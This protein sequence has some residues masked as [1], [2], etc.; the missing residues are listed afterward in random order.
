MES[1]RRNFFNG[2]ENAEQ[3]MLLIGWNKIL[4]SKKNGAIYGIRGALDNSSSYSRRCPW[5][6]IVNEV[7]KLAS[8]GIDLLSLV[9]KKV[10]NGEATSFWNDVWLGD[11]PLKQ[12]YSRLYFL[13]LDKHVSVVSKLRANSLISSFRRSPRSD[14]SGDFSVK[15][16]REFIDDSM[17]PKTDVP[18]RWIKSIPIKINI[19]SWRVS[20]NK[21]PTRLNLSLR[22]L[23]ISSIICP[24]YS[25]VVESTSHLLF[26]CQFAHQLMIKVVYWWDLEYQDFHSYENWILWFKNLRVSK[27]LKD[28]FEGVFDLSTFKARLVQLNIFVWNEVNGPVRIHGGDYLITIVIK[29]RE[30]RYVVQ[31]TKPI[32]YVRSM[33]ESDLRLSS[34]CYKLTYNLPPNRDVWVKTDHDWHF[35]VEFSEERG[36]LVY[37]DLEICPSVTIVIKERPKH[38]VVQATK[39]FETVKSM[40]EVDLSLSPRCYKL[41]YNLPPNGDVCVKTYHDWHFVVQFSKERGYFMYLDLEIC[42]SG[43]TTHLA[44]EDA[45]EEEMMLI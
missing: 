26:S 13:E 2:V 40:I 30:K 33:I 12:M 24:L 14:P 38:N 23:D 16:L 1:I 3:K 10:G 36:Y 18:T 42:P 34:R 37:L 29:E 44:Y 17:L 27:R 28:V 35:A 7:R 39:L 9:K 45:S 8:K 22:F 25:I 6:D 21:M 43:T 4:A 41:T 19:F 5:L 32:E 31:A 20:L 15:S 11:F